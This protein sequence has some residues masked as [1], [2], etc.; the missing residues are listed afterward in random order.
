MC[1]PRRWF[2]R[3]L[4]ISSIYL[5]VTLPLAAITVT[6]LG[7]SGPGTLRAAID[8]ANSDGVPTTITFAA[9]LAGGTI[10]PASF[11]T[12]IQE[13]DTTID[14]DLNDDCVPDIGID[15][16][17]AG[18][19]G[20]GIRAYS[21]RNVIRGLAISR[22]SGHGVLLGGI[23]NVFEC[24]W[25]GLDLA[26]SPGAGNSV[27]GLQVERGPNRIEPGYIF[28]GNGSAGVQVVEFNTNEYP[29]F[30]ALTPDNIR[31]YPFR[32]GFP[33]QDAFL[34]PA[35]CVWQSADGIVPTDGAG[36]PFAENFG[37]RFT[38]Q[39]DLGAGGDYTFETLPYDQRRLV[40][41]GAVV[42]DYSGTGPASTV[43]TG[44]SPGPHT[45]ELDVHK[46]GGAAA[47]GLT[48]T[49]PG[50]ATL[51]TGVSP[52]PG[53][54][55]SLPG[56][57]GEL[58]R[59]RIPA[60]RNTITQNS[61]HDNGGL[62][63]ALGWSLGA[64]C[65]PRAN[66]AGDLD[67]G[68]NTVLNHP[69]ITGVAPAGG[70]SYTISGTAPS[71]ATVELFLSDGDPS[72]HGEGK[73]FLGATTADPGGSF[74]TTLTLA[75]TGAALTAT[76]TD[77]AGNTSEFGPDFRPGTGQDAATV[78]GA[79]AGL[80][81]ATVVV[82]V[83]ARDLSLTPLGVDRPAGELIQSL[84]YK[85]TFTPASSV[86]SKLFARA[87]ITAGLAPIF[88]ATPTT[89]TTASYIG[90]FDEAT[91][92]IPF[93]LDAAAPADQVLKITVTLAAT[94]PAGKIAL[95]LDPAATLFANQAGSIEETSA[96]GW[97]ALA[98]GEITVISNAA[99]ALRAFA[100]SSSAIQL[101][102]TDPNQNETGFRLERSTD[103]MGWSTV[104]TLG[105][106]VSSHLETTGLSPATLYYYRLVTLV[107]ADSHI[108]NRAAASTFPTAAAK[109][110]AQP[111]ATTPGS[112]TSTPSAAWG[113]GTW[114]V[115]WLGRENAVQD[116]IYFQ[117]FA[118]TT[119]AAVGSPTR[120]TASA[121]SA[122]RV[123]ADKPTLAWSD[124][125][126]GRWGVIWTEGLPGEP[127]TP[128]TN[129]TFF[130]LLAPDGSI[131]RGG[132]RIS[133]VTND[134]PFEDGLPAPLAWDGTHWGTF[135]LAYVTPPMLDLVYRRLDADGDVVLGP[136]TVV[137][138]AAAHVSDVDAAWNAATSK[139]GLLWHEIR[140]ND[141]DVYFQVMEESTGAREGS[142][143]H[144][145]EYFTSIGTWGGSVVADGTGW[146]VV[147]VDA[148]YDPD[149]GYIGTSWMQ[150]FD[151]SGAPLGAATRLSDDP[152]TDG[153]MTL[154]A[155]KP[156]GGFAVFG[157]C[158]TVP[159]EVCRFE[160][161]A[162]GVRIG[163]LDNVTPADGFTS[164]PYDVAGNGSDFLVVYAERSP[165]TFELGGTLVPVGDFSAPGT[166]ELLTAGH[167]ANANLPGNS[168]VVPLGGGF[169]AVWLDPT[170]GTNL[171][172]A[173]TWDG[174]GATVATLSPLTPTPARG[175]PAVVA[176]GTELA[177]A[178]RAVATTDLWFARYDASGAPLVGETSVST[179]GSTSN[180]AMDF[181]GEVYGL[182]WQ[183]GGGFNFRRVASNGSPIG[184]DLLV[185][186]GSVANTA[187][188][189]RWVGSGWAV[190]WRSG[191]N[192]LHYAF[193]APDGTPVTLNVTLTSATQ[194]MMPVSFHLI[195]TGTD[196]GLAWA[197]LRDLDPPLDDIV[198][199]RLNL[200]G[201]FAQ[202]A[203]TAV[204]TSLRDLNPQLYWTVG[205]A[206]FHLV[207]SA[208]GIVGA[209]E[210]ELQ[211]DGAVLPG[212]RFWTNRSAGAMAWNGVTLGYVL[213]ADANLYFETSQCVSAD[214]TA[215]PCPE[216]SVASFG[217]LVR[218]DWDPVADPESGIFRYHVYRDGQPLAK[219]FATTTQFDDAGFG[220]GA[221][222]LYQVR[223]LNAAWNESDACPA[224]AYSTTAGDANGD[225][226]Y[227]VADI[228][229]LIN[230][231][232]ADGAPPAGNADANGDNAVTVTDIFYMI[233]DIFSGGPDPLPITGEDSR[234][235]TSAQ[236]PSAGRLDLNP[237]SAIQR[238]G[239]SRLI[240]G[241]ATAA[242]GMTVRMP[243]D[244]VD[245]PG[246]PLGADRPYGDRV[247]A[248][249]LA[250]RC[251]PCD[252]IAALTLEPAGALARFEPIFESRPGGAEQ[253]VLVTAYDETTAPLFLGLSTSERRQRVAT[254]VVQLAPLAS[255][256]TTLDLR[257]DP[258]TTM[259]SNQAGTAYETV[260]NG[261]LELADGRLTIAV[262]PS[263]GKP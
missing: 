97:L 65:S 89:A 195:W 157:A 74:V 11:L 200:D 132:V 15:G 241:S 129:T 46:G 35:G 168:N 263:P 177:V 127:G 90:T 203:V 88:Q 156:G 220:I 223:A 33:H 175:R 227:G 140:D 95:T 61:I 113:D 254:L 240:V 135:E 105:P 21:D 24:N 78:G 128:L 68:A 17:G 184:A 91:N 174:S 234:A 134:H 183:R 164:Q 110:C 87:G 169:A 221:T 36:A 178:W 146:A 57:C 112:W 196:L 250:V 166:P 111:L 5:A 152:P 4:A 148:V 154:L 176:V 101:D 26:Q 186:V 251:A 96:N 191:D 16:A 73:A 69:V 45:L 170:S 85:V 6:S 208:G 20:V 86:A 107:P 58:F 48:I 198:F 75:P 43:V 122:D 59:L 190:V 56:M 136:V 224:V 226:S 9:G 126:F 252:G 257:L 260:P 80:P 162:S 193:L 117:R 12:W 10:A 230:F 233:N 14:G 253:A 63:I 137:A 37:V 50:S 160:T 211:P 67:V 42:L 39:V 120:V 247:Q 214:V 248:L 141:I 139:Y 255:P 243:I 189:M 202:S 133:S 121:S 99:S 64:G 138:P 206:R 131:E 104:A 94:A 222:H 216:L 34:F 77:L 32:A 144:I 219:T 213:G 79:A 167:D 187:P 55:A 100:V 102:W 182:L 171:L 82:P 22:F 8:A 155:R 98:D 215:P 209:R 159:T 212:E 119:L 244:L 217:S 118:A 40:L 194:N 28:A 60:E 115:A 173:R 143:T 116:E 81:G 165:G 229:Y 235:A 108:S 161:D 199:V 207:H 236:Q 51:S 180:I 92:P 23:D 2:L 147:W 49:G 66:D 232:F 27:N 218:L 125:A 142:P 249:A 70:G 93:T 145:D 259:L 245:R 103:G 47:I 71:S 31:R 38:G 150:R 18:T 179:I 237:E 246:T 238:Q 41:D 52:P 163:S 44:L 72:G 228:F 54:G 256:G 13:P 53:C 185:P 204:S 1:T 261:W 158:G 30:T 153:G 114:G 123:R 239:R 231:F 262:R 7:D 205:D 225:G 84:S 181:S 130:S 210:I 192:N 242:P 29:L 3:T 151:A 62:G 25:V 109:I 258:G 201:T 188:Q 19:G 76:A 149:S 106:N 124:P 172:Q 197:E 83:Y